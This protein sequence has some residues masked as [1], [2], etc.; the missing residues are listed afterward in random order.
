M[1]SNSLNKKMDEI[2]D[3]VLNRILIVIML[4][5]VIGITISLLRVSQTGFL[6]N[7]GV[8]IFLAVVI[9]LLYSF[10]RKIS[11]H[12]KGAIFLGT[13]I[14]LALSGLLSFGLYGFGYTYFIPASAIAFVF[15][16]RKTG[17][18]ITFS[19]LG[20]ILLVAIFFNQGILHFTPQKSNYME[21][22]PMWLN[23]IITVSLIATLITMFWNNLFGLLTN[24]FTHINNQQEDMLKMNEQ[25][26]IARDRA[27]ESDKL[28]SAFLANISHEIRTPL[29]IIIGFSDML[30]NT[31]NPDEK[32]EFNQV[33]RH[34]GNVMLKIVNDIVDFSKIETN[35]LALNNSSFNI[36]DVLKEVEKNVLWEKAEE[37]EWECD[38]IDKNIIADK[39]RFHQ[40]LFNLT[41][42]A[43]K[44]TPSGKVKLQC[45][46]Q[47]GKL[48]FRISDTGIGI[49]EKE[50][51][52]I[53]DRFYKVD[54]FTP[55]AGLGLSLSKSIANMM[56][57]DIVFESKPGEGS[58]FEFWLPHYN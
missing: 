39:A 17:W 21:S 12:L 13:I 24:T 33:I 52:H 34:N 9:I 43:I 51:A 56:G 55:G 36:C 58:V 48:A 8:Q 35:T 32:C 5:M 15:F 2:K 45:S 14:T 54:R 57:G 1:H 38:S 42:N 46:E 4:V 23:M 11:T 41:E 37:V 22:L 10:R 6:I 26:V 7:Y 18:I 20:I 3:S 25:L 49:S 47:E 29:N 28:K 31:D 16:N 44:F 50:Q 40:I 53:F 19:G 30:Y 27:E